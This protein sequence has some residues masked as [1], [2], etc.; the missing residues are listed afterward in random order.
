MFREYLTPLDILFIEYDF[1]AINA[2]GC[3]SDFV[4]KKQIIFIRCNIVE[5]DLRNAR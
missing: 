2:I 5:G 1:R 4:K 3:C